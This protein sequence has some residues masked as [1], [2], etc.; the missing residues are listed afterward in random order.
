MVGM[1]AEMEEMTAAGFSK[2]T[3]KGV[4]PWGSG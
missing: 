4:G 2:S 3:R 1:M